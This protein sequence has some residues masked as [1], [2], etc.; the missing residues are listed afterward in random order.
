MA[1]SLEEENFLDQT[2]FELLKLPII[3]IELFTVWRSLISFNDET[4]LLSLFM[5]QQF[6]PKMKIQ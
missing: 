3:P 1:I 2:S 4:F 5:L 6:S